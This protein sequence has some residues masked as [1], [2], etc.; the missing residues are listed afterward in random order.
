[1]AIKSISSD[2]LVI[3]RLAAIVVLLMMGAGCKSRECAPFRLT[4]CPIFGYDKR[5]HFEGKEDSSW[6]LRYDIRGGKTVGNL[7][8]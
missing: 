5:G 7:L 6:V 2:A 4:L 8:V 3:V 1:M